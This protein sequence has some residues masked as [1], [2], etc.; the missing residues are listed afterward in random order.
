MA[1][2]RRDGRT[3]VTSFSVIE[4]FE[5]SSRLL[6]KLRTG[7]TH[8]I[9]VHLS[10]VGH[11]VFGDPTY[12]GRRRKYGSLSPREM[13]RARACLKL[14]DRQAL[15]AQTLSFTHPHTGTKMSFDA[16]LP[17]DMETLIH[18][19]RQGQGKGGEQ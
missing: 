18:T 8:Q 5:F 13:N 17:K 19:L 15:H 11:P 16:P 10:H 4:K 12:G 6:V 9:R 2:R 7:R 3:A 1:V 14:I